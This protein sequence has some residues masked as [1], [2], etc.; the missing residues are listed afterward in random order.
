[1]IKLASFLP[2]NKAGNKMGNFYPFIESELI[3]GG[4]DRLWTRQDICLTD[5]CWDIILLSW[6]EDFLVTGAANSI[7]W[8]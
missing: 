4:E 7:P 2:S 1:M 6:L 8:I 5:E 3:A